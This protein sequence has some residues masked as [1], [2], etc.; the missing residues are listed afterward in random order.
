M[1]INFTSCT[2]PYFVVFLLSPW[3]LERVTTALVG[4]L[5]LRFSSLGRVLFYGSS[6]VLLFYLKGW[7]LKISIHSGERFL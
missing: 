4:L 3:Y 1:A 2:S 7:S 5:T 6:I